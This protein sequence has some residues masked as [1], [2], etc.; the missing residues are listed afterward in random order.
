MKLILN[1]R[2]REGASC[3]KVWYAGRQLPGA[4]V[5]AA[6]RADGLAGDMVGAAVWRRILEAVEELT[7]GRRDGEPL[8]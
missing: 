1:Q 6:R 3:I 5:Y 4:L 8:N 2:V 7:R